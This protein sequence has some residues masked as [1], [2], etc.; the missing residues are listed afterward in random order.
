MR[1]LL[2]LSILLIAGYAGNYFRIP[3]V[4]HADWLFGSIAA[5]I[6]LKL[7]GWG[8]GTVAG[9]IASSYTIL[10]WKHPCA[11]ILFTLETFFVGWGLRRRSNNLLLL[12]VV[13]WGFIGFPLLWLLYVFLAKVEPSSVLFL[14]FKNPVNQIS[15]ALLA[16][17][18]LNHT[19][20][21]KWIVGSKAEKTINFEQTLLNLF[22]AF[23]LIPALVLT[24]WNCQGA[25]SEQEHHILASLENTKQN[26]STEL[27]NWHQQK[28][29]MLERLVLYA[30]NANLSKSNSLQDTTKL[31]YSSFPEIRNLYITDE[32]GKI[33]VSAMPADVTTLKE[34]EYKAL[35]MEKQPRISEVVFLPGGKYPSIIQSVPILEDESVIGQVFAEIDVNAIASWLTNNHQSSTQL[36]TILDLQQRAIVS[37]RKDLK[38][39]QPFDR[40]NNGEIQQLNNTTYR[41]IPTVQHLAK[42]V[43]WRKSFYVQKASIGNNLPWQLAI[44]VPSAPYLV[45]LDKLYTNGFAVLMV[46]AVLTPLLAK[47][48]SYNLVKPLLQLANLTTN[49]PDKLI[50]PKE[51]E[52]PSS[53]ITEIN[54]LTNNFQLMAIAL[55]NKF[56]E[57]QQAN[58]EIQQAKEAADAANQ[59]KSEFLAN[60]SHEL[61]TPLNGILGYTQI[62]QRS[63]SLTDKGRKGI[64]IIGQ[65]G[66]HLLTLIN[67]VL[68]LSKIEARKLELNPVYFYLPSFLE[69]VTE[70]CRIRAEQ[71]EI[72]FTVQLDSNL[73]AGI[74]ADEKRLRQVLINLLGNAIKFTDQGKVTFK[75]EVIGDRQELNLPITDDQLPITKIRFE[76]EDT[77]V[78]MKTNQM[79][80]IFR[81]FEQV[82]E[83]KQQ[84]EGTGLGLAISQRIISLMGSKIE[85]ISEFGKGSK[86]WFEVEVLQAKEWAVASRVVQQ[87]TI[88]G[89]QGKKRTILVVDD[90]WENRSVIVNLL[91]PI[92]FTIVEAGDGQEGWEIAKESKPDA[93]VTDL[94]MPVMHGFEF[95]K[96]LRTYEQF[97]QIPVVASSASV[98][99]TDQ[100]KS[101][102]AGANAFLPK[103]VDAQTLMQLL[104]EYLQLEWIYQGNADSSTS[105]VD[106]IPPAREVLQ[107]LVNLVQDGDIQGVVEMAQKLPLS[108]R[109]LTPFA[110]EIVQLAN[111]FQVK[112]LESFIEQYID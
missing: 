97:K 90:K 14:S 47:A 23:V 19:P 59:A 96:R 33:I 56:Q 95:I 16:C 106:L 52:F 83:V 6:V 73:P 44:E 86:F 11:F 10:L 41:W 74:R 49:L 104:Q 45:L 66:S 18:I 101:I 5:I 55:Q 26:V 70:I 107:Q 39:L 2:L 1:S 42:V 37:T 61:R 63:E 15:N 92:G 103:P 82:G 12:D 71:K 34:P 24:I 58:L 69:S 111:S 110:A 29:Q 32:R 78:G 27:Q 60:M 51:L 8:W 91:E 89:Y 13:Y 105:P 112:R 88:V 31:A 72:A 62:L 20:I 40:N 79:E 50:A 75:V 85:V 93:I 28:Q 67:D 46:I 57:I 64:E 76:V 68:D 48:I 100:Y 94:V 43:R 3:I 21:A 7:Y 99:E 17:L 53:Q 30:K 65:C 36:I 102:N 9:A 4:L 54:A 22:V 84:A 98:F 108:D 35:L 87:G 80:K 77:G 109:K 25:A 38:L 81:P